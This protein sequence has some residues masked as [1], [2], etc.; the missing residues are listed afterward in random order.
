MKLAVLIKQVPDTQNVRMDEES[1]TV[2]R[3]SSDAVLNPLD[4]YALQAALLLKEQNPQISIYAFSMG[5]PS[6]EKALREVLALGADEAVLIS[7]RA[8]AGSDTLATAV[9][10]AAALEK[11]APF[12][13]VLCGERATDGDTGQVGPEL[14]AKLNF[15]LATFVNEL[16]HTESGLKVER[17]SEY[18]SEE[19]L[20]KYPALVTVTKAIGEIGLPTLKNKMAARR[21][22][23]S[24]VNAADLQLDPDSIG[25]KGSP[26]RVVK[27][28]YP[29]LSRKG[30]LYM[31]EDDKSI[32]LAVS[33]FENFVKD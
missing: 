13:L 20:L 22:E 21:K 3:S 12:Q 11:F 8:C 32:E 10:L 16:S 28:F 29:S 15:S 27:I 5:P 33:K 17:K 14:A 1:G 18:A 25:L 30:E 24:R 23:I 26:T 7:D 4:A 9:I 19:W 6:A 2:L 31:A